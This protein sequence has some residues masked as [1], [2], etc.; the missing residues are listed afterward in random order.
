[1]EILDLK[2]KVSEIKKFH[3]LDLTAKWKLQRKKLNEIE[4]KA[5]IQEIIQGEQQREK[6]FLK[7]KQSLRDLPHDISQSNIHVNE[8][9]EREKK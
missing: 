5:V 7:N 1:M 4:G 8:I 6:W 3:W 2:I 9:P